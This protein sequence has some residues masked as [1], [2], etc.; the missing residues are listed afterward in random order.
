MTEAW[1]DAMQILASTLRLATPLIFDL[2]AGEAIRDV[3]VPLLRQA[4]LHVRVFGMPG[5]R[6]L[7]E[8]EIAVYGAADNSGIIQKTDADG[9]LSLNLPAGAYRVTPS[10]LVFSPHESEYVQLDAGDSEELTF[11]LTPLPMLHGV[12]TDRDGDARV[13]GGQ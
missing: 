6:P 4:H 5:T 2:D 11:T 3:T 8:A 10:H 7:A 13:R 12:V 1:I 9:R